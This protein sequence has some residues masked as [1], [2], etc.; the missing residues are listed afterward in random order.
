MKKK[1]NK[2]FD[3]K[4]EK[5]EESYGRGENFMYYPK[6]ETVKFLNRFVKKKNHLKSMCS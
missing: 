4:K 2:M 6:E 5:W 3:T 1:E